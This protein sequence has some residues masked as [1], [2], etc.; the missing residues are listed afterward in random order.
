MPNAVMVKFP[1]SQISK[2]TEIAQTTWFRG[3]GFD[4][5]VILCQKKNEMADFWKAVTN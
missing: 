2:N 4:F 5:G 3:G 1:H